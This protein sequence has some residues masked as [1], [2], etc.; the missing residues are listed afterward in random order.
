MT[1]GS[2]K[3]DSLRIRTDGYKPPGCATVTTL[4][5]P[6]PTAP[7]ETVATTTPAKGRK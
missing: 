5:F 6:P 2:A 3:F 4:T 7:T 1:A